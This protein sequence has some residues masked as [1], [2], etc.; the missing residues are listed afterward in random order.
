M[1]PGKRDSRTP[2]CSATT[3]GW[4]LVVGEH[5]A[6]RADPDPRGRG[7]DR[8]REHG[9]GGTGDAG[10]AVVLGDPEPVV[11]QR[12]DLAGRSGRLPAAPRPAPH[13]YG[14]G[15]GPAPRSGSLPVRR[16]V[17]RSWNVSGSPLHPPAAGTRSRGTGRRRESQPRLPESRRGALP[18]NVRRHT[19]R[20]RL[21]RHR[22]VGTPDHQRSARVVPGI[23]T[24]ATATLDGPARFQRVSRVERGQTAPASR[25]S[26]RSRPAR[27]VGIRNMAARRHG[28]TWHDAWSL[29]R[30]TA[31][32]LAGTCVLIR[33]FVWSG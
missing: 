24:D 13:R 31:K 22:H 25:A 17:H 29:T 7:G 28:T 15:S 23:P 26:W 11:T 3:S 32:A 33:A 19:P 12:L 21:P 14:C 27:V 18:R 10:H 1:R 16:R 20:L 9:G 6:A 30:K 2:N 5:H 4:W 8:R